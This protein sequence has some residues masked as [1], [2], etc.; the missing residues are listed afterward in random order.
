MTSNSD[1]P[2]PDLPEQRVSR[3]TKPISRFLHVEAASGIVLLIATATALLLANLSA[4]SEA[5][6]DF[7]A[8]DVGI[9]FGEFKIYHSLK[10]WINDGLM[11]IFFFVIGLEVKREL[12]LGELRDLRQAVLPAAA[13][14]GG[15]VVP[16][17]IFLTMQWG[18]PGQSGW[19]IPM[20]TDIAFVVGCMAVLGSRVPHSLRVLLLTLAII[21]DIGAI[22]VIAIGYTDDVSL[23]YLAIGFALIGVVWIFERWGVRRVP[24]YVVLGA[25]VWFCFHE[26]GIHATIAGVILG[27]M[28]PARSWVSGGLISSILSRSSNIFSGE[29]DDPSPEHQAALRRIRD[30]SHEAMSPLERLEATLHPWV[31]FVIMPVFAMANAG[32]LLDLSTLTEPISMAVMAGL[33]IGKPVGVVLASWLVIKLGLAKLPKSI[34]WRMLVGGGLLAGIGFTMALFIAELAIKGDAEMLQTTKLAILAASLVAAILGMIILA[35]SP[36]P[37]PGEGRKT[38]T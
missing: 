15:M 12:V 17:G 36:K 6:L 11:A 5:F 38:T 3:F 2:L 4:T 16:A 20:A 34:T 19:G 9:T 24:V 1:N 31:S 14:L 21:D 30:A 7:W 28:T 10:H 29:D 37:D 27:L 26:S 18:E 23:G 32:I 33:V 35:T 22:L 13:A 8:Q 25:C